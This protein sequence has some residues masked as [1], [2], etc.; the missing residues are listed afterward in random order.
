MSNV[1]LLPTADCEGAEGI[2]HFTHQHPLRFVDPKKEEDELHC[3]NTPPENGKLFVLV[4]A[5][6]YQWLRRAGECEGI[7]FTDRMQEPES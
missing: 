2:Q 3:S 6:F 5:H 4:Q 1:P 7:S